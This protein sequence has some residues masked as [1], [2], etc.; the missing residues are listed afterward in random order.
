[1]R[2]AIVG[3]RTFNDIH[4]L[5][6]IMSKLSPPDTIISGGAIGADTVA[7]NYAREN[8]IEL[9]EFLPDWKKYGRAAGMIRNKTIIDSA[10]AVLAFWDGKSKGT[11]NSIALAR[12]RKIPL[13]I[14]IYEI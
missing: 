13:W 14:E 12:K 2:L 3:G 9:V 10:D 6:E 11:K 4:K 8:N 1:M 5:N 7:A